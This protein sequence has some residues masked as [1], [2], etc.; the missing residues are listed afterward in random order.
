MQLN[1]SQLLKNRIENPEE[2]IRFFISFYIIGAIGFLVP[3]TFPFFLKLIPFV[4]LFNFI[5]LML[6]HHA[7]KR[8]IT[9][10][11][12]SAIFLTGFFIEVVGVN[13]KIIFGEYWYGESLGPKLFFTPLMIG[14]NW[15]FLVYTT[16]SVFENLKVNSFIKIILSSTAMVVYD[17]VLEQVA[18]KIGMWYWKND[19]VPLRNFAAWF[20]I[21][22][23]LNSLIKLFHIETNN[24][25][26][27]PILTC[28]FLFF[29]ILTFLLH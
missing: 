11:L 10:I 3:I 17:F 9:I 27:I 4:L 23:F 18:P 28:Q 6:F 5:A 14:I 1:I 22:I 21:A 7:R 19:L 16:S 29:L 26:A 25:L 15:L 12:F 2:T 24:K 13:N 8:A 20:I